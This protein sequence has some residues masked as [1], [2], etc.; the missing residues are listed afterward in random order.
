[1]ASCQSTTAFDKEFA[2]AAHASSPSKQSM[3]FKDDIL[4][5]NEEFQRHTGLFVGSGHEN[6]LHVP[7][8]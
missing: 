4:H 7:Y 6:A 8:W 3:A 2:G 1:M 5:V